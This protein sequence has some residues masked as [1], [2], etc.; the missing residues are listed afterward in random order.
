MS[1]SGQCPVDPAVGISSMSCYVPRQRVRLQQ[2]CDW[3]DTKWDKVRSVT[4]HSF[5]MCGPHEDVYTMAANAVLRLVLRE[6]VDVR[7]IG[8][9]A[10]GT[11]SSS[12]NAVGTVTVAGMVDRELR[13]RGLPGL[14]R[15]LEVPEYKHACLGGMYALVGAARFGRCDPRGR[16]AVVVAADIAEYERGS[17]GEQTQGAGAVA[18]LVQRSPSLLALDL[19]DVTSASA[20]RGPDFRKPAGRYRE[21]DYAPDARR[22]ADFP[23]FS[24]RYSTVAYL[25]EVSHCVEAL[26]R[27]QRRDPLRALREVRAV[28]MH[29]PYRRMPLQALSF[30]HVRALAASPE[31]RAE[32]VRLSE[33]AGVD[34]D[35][36][37]DEVGGEPDLFAE[38]LDGG[39]PDPY[40]ASTAVS[41]CLRKQPAFQESA[42][43][44]LDRGAS[45]LDQVG[46]LYA[47][48]LPAGLAAGLEEAAAN[49][50]ELVGASM[51]AVGYGSGDAALAVPVHAVPG[52]QAAAHRIGFADALRDPVDLERASYEALHDRR[53]VPG[54]HLR[55]TGEFVIERTGTKYGGSFQDL[56]VPYYAYQP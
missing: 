56:A 6:D 40:P 18:M 27:R 48:S 12:D 26:W 24:G 5:R 14:T 32:L 43:Q 15:D 50:E 17:S 44:K 34:S 8:Y 20:C 28:F 46:N 30:L 4:G 41:A 37:L 52:W 19:D 39:R 21:D 13:R 36:V 38:V 10:L 31:G 47:A 55:P 45:L 53:E 16:T 35:A 9:I 42:R 54:R 2:W 3:T 7:R 1:R 25:D 23:V 22:V 51:L 49:E 11:E 29:R 33:S